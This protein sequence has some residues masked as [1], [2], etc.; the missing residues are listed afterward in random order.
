MLHTSVLA[1]VKDLNSRIYAAL[2]VVFVLA[3]AVWQRY[4]NGL[5]Q[6]S[7]PFLASL[8]DNWRAIDV[9][10]RDT[11]HTYQRLHK[12]YGDVVRVGPRVLSFGHP[13]AIADIYGLNKGY[14][15][16]S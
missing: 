1:G 4:Q 13:D 16:V 11:H 14:A 5:S 7:G 8:T 15:K 9:W 6:Y 2:F 10:K 12:K 3:Y